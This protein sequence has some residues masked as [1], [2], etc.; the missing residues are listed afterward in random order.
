MGVAGVAR[1]GG[2][3]GRDGRDRVLDGA[4][5][6]GRLVLG[7]LELLLRHGAGNDPRTGM[8]VRAA[9]AKDGGA[10][11]DRG[12][13]VPVVAEV[14]DG[15]AVEAAALAFGSGDEL[16]GADLRGTRQRPGWEHRA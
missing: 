14:A 15:A 4:A 9:F 13:H 8:D 11:R 6:R 5:K 10:D 1:R 7:L 3:P 12:V 16:H 2:T